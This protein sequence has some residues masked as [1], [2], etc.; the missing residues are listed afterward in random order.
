MNFLLVTFLI[1]AIAGFSTLIESKDGWLQ[2]IFTNMIYPAYV[3]SVT[4]CWTKVGEYYTDSVNLLKGS[5]L[6][7]NCNETL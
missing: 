1:M 6:T 7:G 3:M 2:A 5:S 4:F